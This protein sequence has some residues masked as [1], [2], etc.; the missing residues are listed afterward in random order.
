MFV[1]LVCESIWPWAFL[2]VGFFDAVLYIGRCE[3]CFDWVYVTW[4]DVYIT[5]VAWS[6]SASSRFSRVYR[7]W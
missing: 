6:M 4:L 7:I 5:V 2:V 1:E 3:E